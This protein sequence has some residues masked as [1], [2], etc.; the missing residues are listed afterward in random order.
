MRPYLS[1]GSVPPDIITIIGKIFAI[2]LCS[3]PSRAETLISTATGL[4]AVADQFCQHT[5]GLQEGT[6]HDAVFAQE[7]RMALCGRGC[8]SAGPVVGRLA[9]GGAGIETRAHPARRRL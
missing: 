6:Y 3:A 9:N 2:R 5:K 4:P 8:A 7:T 1:T